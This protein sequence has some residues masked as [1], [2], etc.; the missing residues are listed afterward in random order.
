M[1]KYFIFAAFAGIALASCTDDDFVGNVSPPAEEEALAPISFS[2]SQNAFTRADFVGAEAAD[3]LGG[4]FVV[5]GFKGAKTQTVGNVVFDNYLV[6]YTENTAHKTESNSSNWE[7]VGKGLIPHAVTNGITQQATKYWDYMVDQYD[8][9]AWSTGGKTAVYSGSYGDGEVLVSNILPNSKS[10]SWDTDRKAYTFSGKAEDLSQCFISD[11]VTVLKTGTEG[12]NTVVGYNKTVKLT[13]RQLGTKVRIGIYETIPGYSVKNVE[14]YSAAASSDASAAAKIFT[15]EANGIY[16]EG[17]YTV[18][19]PTVDAPT[20]AD[21]NQAHIEFEP[22]SAAQKTTV[23]WGGLN[24]TFRESGE[25][26]DKAIYLGRSSNTAS[27]AGTPADNYYVVY[28]PN[29]DGTNL[30]LRVNYTLESIDGSKETIVVK[31]A[32]AQVPS[33]YTAWKPGYAYTYLFK[34]S[35]ETNGFTGPYDPTH[36]DDLSTE[37]NPAGLYPITFDALV[38][39]AEEDAT[40]ETITTVSAPS[41]TT[42]QKGSNVVNKNEYDH[43]TGPIFV[44]VNDGATTATPDLTNSKTVTLITASGDKQAALYTLPTDKAYTE[45][46]VIDA[47]QMQ[48]DDAPST[49]AGTVKGR[50]GIVLTPADFS[51]ETSIEYGVDGNAISLT[52]LPNP[53]GSGTY[54]ANAMKFTAAAAGTYAFVYTKTAKTGT[55]AK[56]Y[57]AKTFADGA[58]VNGYYRYALVAATTPVDNSHTGDVEEGVTYFNNSTASSDAITAF[59]GQKVDNLFTRTGSGTTADPYVYTPA[60]GYAQT[61][62]TYYYTLDG[63]TYTDANKVAY[64]DFATKTLYTDANATTAKPDGDP[65]N[66]Q[67]YYTASKVYCVIYP[68]RTTGLYIIDKAEASRVQCGTADTAVKGMTYFDMYTQNNGVY[69]AKIIKVQ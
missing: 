23:D 41:I 19:F 60:R 46:D 26:S 34:I 37:S 67:A 36:P 64:A 63:Q 12:T 56:K 45:A 18:Y 62:T 61:G 4:K 53:S 49:P 27:Y 16:K 65:V 10:P 51:L 3:K 20:N 54:S 42:Y 55:D 7:Y 39:N 43:A 8:F 30:N 22:G 47:M 11:L 57:Q 9:F 44:T 24:Y 1:K 69:Y 2:S 52:A 50:S 21:N 29:Q 38:V 68:Q 31:G 15:T 32:T 35:D 17:T 58:S 14:F 40:Q 48:D 25:T 59:L 5:T 66:G 33:I 13:F 28:L 6:E